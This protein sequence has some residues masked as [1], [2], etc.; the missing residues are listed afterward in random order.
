MV[1]RSA[2]E[3]R[4]PLFQYLEKLVRSFSFGVHQPL[5]RL[6]LASQVNSMSPLCACFAAAGLAGKAGP[7]SVLETE[8]SALAVQRR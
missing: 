6:R 1:S 7:V 3:N 2:L 4:V 8:A 5:P